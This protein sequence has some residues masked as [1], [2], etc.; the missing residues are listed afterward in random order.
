MTGNF[1]HYVEPIEIVND[2]NRQVYVSS[3]T[4]GGLELYYLG[5]ESD[6]ARA[7][8]VLNV[9]ELRSLTAVLR[10]TDPAHNPMEGIGGYYLYKVVI[11]SYPDGALFF[12]DGGDGDMYGEPDR[13]WRPEGWEPDTEWLE[14]FGDKFFWPSTKFEYKSKSSAQSR[15]KLIES[16]GA[17][18]K[19]VRSSLITWP[20]SEV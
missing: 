4:V 7:D 9:D 14:R 15:A 17:T 2:G 3:G 5:V 12:Y 19:V 1:V 10:G 6:A 11:T 13:D 16:Y 18:A 8:V 20:S